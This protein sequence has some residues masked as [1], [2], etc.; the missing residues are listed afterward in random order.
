MFDTRAKREVEIKLRL[1]SAEQGRRLLRRAGFRVVRRRVHEDNTVLDTPKG[2]LRKQGLLL[3]LR[4][5]G[6]SATLT[7]KGPAAGGKYKS[8]HELETVLSDVAVCGSIFDS[9]GFKRVFRYEK[10]R[11]EYQ[12]ADRRG[13]VALDETPV[14]VFL[15]LEGDPGWIDQTANLLGFLESDYITI[16]YGGLYGAYCRQRGSHPGDM[17]FGSSTPSGGIKGRPKRAGRRDP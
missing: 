9:L 5:A 6:R 7:L 13:V 8:R 16:T 10:Y 15:E 12:G 11:T 2:S 14:G 17:V 1:K 3:R 4:K